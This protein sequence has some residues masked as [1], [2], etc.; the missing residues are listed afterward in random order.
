MSDQGVDRFQRKAQADAQRRAQLG[1]GP[2][3][4]TATFGF[5]MDWGPALAQLDAFC[6]RFRGLGALH[7]G[8]MVEQVHEATFGQAMADL[9]ICREIAWDQADETVPRD[10]GFLASTGHSEVVPVTSDLGVEGGGV[11]VGRYTATYAAVVHEEPDTKRAS[12]E[13]KWLETAWMAGWFEFTARLRRSLPALS[14]RVVPV[15]VG[16]DSVHGRLSVERGGTVGRDPSGKFRS[17][18]G[19]TPIYE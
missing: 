7:V 8:G 18:R 14:S 4:L 6:Q 19:A 5:R 15:L 1:D 13:R 10:T 2:G 16:Y 17:L 9:E 3:E 12:G 11:A